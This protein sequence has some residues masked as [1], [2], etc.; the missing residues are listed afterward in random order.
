MYRN[1]AARLNKNSLNTFKYATRLHIYTCTMCIV[2]VYGMLFFDSI[3]EDGNF[4][5]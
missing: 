4:N 1:M 3:F 5:N 2:H